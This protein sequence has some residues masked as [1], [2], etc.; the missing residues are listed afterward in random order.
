MLRAFTLEQLA[1]ITGEPPERLLDWRS[2]GLIGARDGDGFTHNDRE[3]ARLVQLCLRRGISLDKI[4]EADRDSAPSSIVTSDDVPRGARPDVFFRGGRRTIGAGPGSRRDMWANSGLLAEQGDTLREEDVEA[5]RAFKTYHDAG[6]P[7]AALGEGTRVF[8]DSLARVA[9]M[10]SIRFH[11]RNACER[12]SE[13]PGAF[14]EGGSGET[15][16]MIRL[17]RPEGL[18]VLLSQSIALLCEQPGVRPHVP[19]EIQVQPR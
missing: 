5:F 19:R 7:D 12:V 10:E 17:E 8:A 14:A 3:R 15:G 13:D 18:D 11:L 1:A 9:E 16:V 2:R 4:A 6:F